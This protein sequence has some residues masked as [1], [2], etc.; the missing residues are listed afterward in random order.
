[1]IELP[2]SITQLTQKIAHWF[3]EKTEWGINAATPSDEAVHEFFDQYPLSSLLPYEA[4]DAK[5]AVF[6]NKKSVGFILEASTLTGCTE[7]IENILA[8]LIS[9]VIPVEADIQFL[10]WASPK[11][12]D[13]LDT[14]EAARSGKGETFEWL[15][16]QRTD[17]LKKGTLQSLTTSGQFYL[18][19]FKLYLILSL[20]KKDIDVQS[21]QLLELRQDIQSSL[22]SV[23]IATR[24]IPIENF[25]SLMMDLLNPSRNC[26]A[27]RETWNELDA[28]NLQLTDPEYR[29]RVF[30]NRLLLDTEEEAWDV[31]CFSVRQFPKQMS[32]GHMTENIGQLFNS[33]L[34]MPC[35]FV[36]SLSIR[37]LDHEKSAANAQMKYMNKDSTARSPLAKFK[38]NADKEYQDW[39]HVRKQLADGDRLVKIYYQVV[40]YSSVEQA[41][42]AERKVRDLYRANGWKLCKES[43]VQL[44]SWLAMLPMMMTEGL[45]SRFKNL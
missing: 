29:L 27:R 10:L 31:R 35:P 14:F 40:T 4:Y 15:A 16:K 28:L 44:Q 17:F 41:N 32:Q 19:D 11:I 34:Q 36:I 12:G 43:C 6:I 23:H 30:R 8:S 22:K 24:D 9:D 21:E 39:S 18:R 37:P 3:G 1:M 38:P 5:N 7:E 45:L 13:V 42:S 2:E 25:I 26:Y 20:P 33:A